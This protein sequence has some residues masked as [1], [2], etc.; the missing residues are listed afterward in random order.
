MTKWGQ[1]PSDV[2]PTEDN[3]YLEKSK[4]NDATA[5]KH[6]D[7][8]GLFSQLWHGFD[9]IVVIY[10]KSS[11][12]RGDIS[13]CYSPSWRMDK[14]LNIFNKKLHMKRSKDDRRHY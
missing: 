2:S 7:E 12:L 13:N 5:K 14:C 9:S 10:C 6:S 11:D 4:G 1:N 3:D 8:N